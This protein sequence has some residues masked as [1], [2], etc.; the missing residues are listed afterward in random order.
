MV[1]VVVSSADMQYSQDLDGW[2]EILTNEDITVLT[3]MLSFNEQAF[4]KQFQFEGNHYNHHTKYN[5]EHY[6]HFI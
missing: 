6:C 1:P 4:L 3:I 5:V 2:I